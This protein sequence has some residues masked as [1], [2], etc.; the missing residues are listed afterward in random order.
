MKTKIVTL[1]L[2]LS[3]ILL[4]PALSQAQSR[5]CLIN[6]CNNY[7]KSMDVFIKLTSSGM[8][9]D[10]SS[11]LNSGVSHLPIEQYFFRKADFH[12]DK[13]D[14][15]NL[16]AAELAIEGTK[17]SLVD[18]GHDAMIAG[19]KELRE[20]SEK[21]GLNYPE[22]KR[23]INTE[24]VH[25]M[26]C[27]YFET[28]T[29]LI[30]TDCIYDMSANAMKSRTKKVGKTVNANLKLSCVNSWQLYDRK[31]NA[32]TDHFQTEGA[33]TETWDAIDKKLLHE[34]TGEVFM[35]M[36]NDRGMVIFG[37]SSFIPLLKR[38][39]IVAGANFSDNL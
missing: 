23:K 20:I 3:G 16:T 24:Q 11:G 32:I 1:N 31:T 6:E 4:F 2:I 38:V 17:E 18:A 21:N 15:R 29:I 27:D 13:T 8:G 36:V 25:N 35:N 26:L 12:Y 5:V 34:K 33:Y 28:D 10:A 7:P 37:R 19:E 14:I 39:G 30:L 22:L 9:G